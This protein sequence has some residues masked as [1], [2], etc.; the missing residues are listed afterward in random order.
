MESTENISNFISPNCCGII[1]LT[2]DK[3]DISHPSVYEL[4]YLLDGLLIKTLSEKTNDNDTNH[5]FLSEN[6]GRPFFIGHVV[7]SSSAVKSINDHVSMIIPLVTEKSEIY[8]LN[9]TAKHQSLV[10]DLQKK[11]PQLTFKKI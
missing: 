1:W 10:K 9:Q 8:I 3:V 11:Y 6:F 2:Q 5:F 7:D 4:N